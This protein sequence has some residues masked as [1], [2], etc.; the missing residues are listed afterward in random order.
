MK[1]QHRY[2]FAAGRVRRFAHG[3]ALVTFDAPPLGPGRGIPADGIVPF[4]YNYR[5]RIGRPGHGVR[6]LVRVGDV[7][8]IASGHIK[9]G[10]TVVRVRVVVARS[11]SRH[12][13]Q[14]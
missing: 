2:G 12:Q 3:G 7:A 6:E 10:R 5:L 8:P 11:Q 14:G 9:N 1:T 13:Q 4:H